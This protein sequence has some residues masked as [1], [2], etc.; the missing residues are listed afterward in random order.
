MSPASAIAC[1]SLEA[2]VDGELSAA[3]SAAF[4]R[5]VAG[6]S[7]CQA[8]LE[9]QLR[10]RANLRTTLAKPAAGEDL[11]HR[12]LAALP[13]D[14]PASASRPVARRQWLAMAAAAS[15]AAILASSATLYVVRPSAEDDWQ[16]A[17]LDSHL[18]A[19][20]SGH[21]I[22]VASSD[23]HTVKPWFGG[24]TKIAPIVL[25]LADV[26]YPLLGGRLDI[27]QKDALPVLVYKA[28]PHVV[29]VF[30][31]AADGPAPAGIAK[32]DGF[33]IL[34][35]SDDGLAYSAVSDADGAELEA[36]Q[37]AFAAARQKLP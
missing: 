20:L 8:Q 15:V 37:R 2:Y 19:T 5:H 11:R 7:A 34:N 18:R 22:D 6:C 28:G 31:R 27:P 35:W 4:D 23:R 13:Q 17:I 9:R 33:S 10:L 26:G 1:E 14:R 32:I 24:K 30:V 25:D 36:F 12:I 3:E 21:V 29:S 16:Q